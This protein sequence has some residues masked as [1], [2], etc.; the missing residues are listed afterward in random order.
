[1]SGLKTTSENTPAV[2]V[3]DRHEF[4]AGRWHGWWIWAEGAPP[5]AHH[6]V[7]LST[8]FDLDHVA[9]TIPARWFA[10]SKAM[11]Y[12]N[13]RLASSG[14]VR[15]NPRMHP[16]EDFNLAPFL[17]LGT[18]HVVAIATNY[19]SSTPWYLPMPVFSSDLAQGAFVFE[20]D[21]GDRWLTSD[22]SWMATTLQGWG[23]TAKAGISG[24]GTETLDTQSLPS[25]WLE[26][27][28]GAPAK[29]RRAFAVGEP[30][31]RQPP[32][33][34]IGPFGQRPISEPSE[35]E[36][37]LERAG[38][39]SWAAGHIVAGSL[40]AD[41]EGP[42]GSTVTIRVSEFPASKIE[43]DTTHDSCF[44]IVCDGTRRNVQSLERYG[45]QSYVVEADEGVELHGLSVIERLY[46]VTGNA[47]FA[48][49]D[50]LLEQISK[51]GRRSI[52]LNSDD[53]YTDCPTREQRA[54]TGD[55][56]VH[57]MVDL[58]TNG[59]WL[60]ARH[61]VAMIAGSRRP[62]GML[63]MAVSGDAE[64]VDFTIIADWALHWVHSVWNLYRYV[65]DRS[66]IAELL[67]V[68]EGVLRWF[69]P[70]TD[71]T[72]LLRDV[73]GWVIIDWSSVDTRGASSALNGLFGRALLEYEEMSSWLKDDSRSSWANSRHARL[74][75]GFEALWDDKRRR[76]VDSIV[77]SDTSAL[78]ERLTASEH[79]QAAA[80]VGGLVPQDRLSRLVEVLQN[81][82]GRVCAT[83][84]APDG[85]AEPNSEIEVGGGYLRDGHPEPWWDI[86]GLVV[87]QPF[88]SY[89]VH[90]ALV[91][92]GAG[93]TMVNRCRKWQVALQRCP[94]SWT[95]TWFGGTISH[96]WSSTPTRDLVQRVLGIT[97]AEAGF[98]AVAVEPAIG[99]LEWAE[100]T[101]PTPHGSI[102][103]RVTPDLID[104]SSPL[105]LQHAGQMYEPGHH[106]IERDH[107]DNDRSLNEHS[108]R[109][110]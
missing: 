91:L 46:P 10:V 49:S 44:S 47:R 2:L 101:V 88:F 1:M 36:I 71:E 22:E 70:F 13:G 72:G 98:A 11:V 105:P 53:A 42:P 55:S 85:P 15:G 21:L 26:G 86:D 81:P 66:E 43:P 84:S 56:V 60:L 24:R 67:H 9:N 87:A 54:W 99:D 63:P 96:G 83:Y 58:T 93:E 103:I 34:P 16:Y 41:V 108:G 19:S 57:Q 82:I 51:V 110:A 102:Q 4:R 39:G 80:I 97:P 20:A 31:L 8:T 61:N 50:P 100:G 6:V 74:V 65:G 27:V 17:R 14:P 73:F 5:S 52:S 89:V 35:T 38:Q 68:V 95:E 76:Y 104:I 69:D 94:T 30:E 33:Y 64:E 62:D 78:G 32:S 107:T 45:G 37:V 48:C 18:N 40:L 59:D 3:K 23:A 106:L 109:Q 79:G 75:E 90:D 12:V 7:A 28:Q 25:D 92:A 77:G 29:L